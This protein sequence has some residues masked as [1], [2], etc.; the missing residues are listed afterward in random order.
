LEDII[1]SPLSKKPATFVYA[2][3]PH[4]GADNL[5]WNNILKSALKSRKWFFV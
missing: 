4:G 3:R 5:H 2:E 1:L